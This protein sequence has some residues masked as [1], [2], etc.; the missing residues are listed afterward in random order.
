[1]G[2]RR[3]RRFGFCRRCGAALCACLRAAVAAVQPGDSARARRGGAA[4]A[5]RDRTGGLGMRQ[6]RQRSGLPALSGADGGGLQN[7]DPL[8]VG[9]GDVFVSLMTFGLALGVVWVALRGIP[10]GVV[11][12]YHACVVCVPAAFL[13]LRRRRGGDLTIPVLL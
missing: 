9:L 7:C 12:A 5:D 10:I 3:R 8:V 4:A 2:N 11:A 13:V 6:D 1:A